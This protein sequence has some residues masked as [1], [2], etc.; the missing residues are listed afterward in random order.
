MIKIKERI[1]GTGAEK[2][3]KEEPTE[4]EE[5]EKDNKGNLTYLS[6]EDY[7]EAA[8]KMGM[9]AIKYYDLR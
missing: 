3:E 7:Q 6:E 9:A 4:T 1:S 8:E 5:E 2:E